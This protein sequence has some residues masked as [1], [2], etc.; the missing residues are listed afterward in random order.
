M[1]RARRSR[2]FLACSYSRESNVRS[3]IHTVTFLRNFL[4][5]SEILQLYIEEK[6]FRDF[7][8]VRK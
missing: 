4:D 3:T 5:F 6:Y 7:D 2:N 8:V 1:F